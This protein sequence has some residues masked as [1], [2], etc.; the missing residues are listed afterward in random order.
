MMAKIFKF[1]I[2]PLFIFIG[3]TT[4]YFSQ[5]QKIPISYWD[6]YEW[7]GRSYFFELFVKN[8]TKN[9]LWKGLYSYD[10][11][12]LTHYLQGAILYP[13]Y[14]YQKKTK[15][16]TYGYVKFLVDNNFYE[17]EGLNYENYKSKVLGY[18]AW[19]PQDTGTAEELTLKFGDNFQ[20][21]IGLIFAARKANIFLLSGSVLLV[22]LITLISAGFSIALIITPFYG[23]NNLII[24][25]GLV[26]HSEALFLALFNL[27]LLVLILIFA[28]ETK[29]R[30]FLLVIFPTIAGLCASTKLNG[31]MLLIFFDSF[32]LF[33]LIPF[34]QKYFVS[35]VNLLSILAV[36]IFTLF[37]F[38]FLNP[39]LYENPLENTQF[40]FEWRR[41][42]VLLQMGGW[43]ETALPT[44]FD[45]IKQIYSN[46]F[47]EETFNE[48]N[49]IPYPR[50][51]YIFISYVL[52]F[53][54]IL[55]IFST[56][57]II[58]NRTAQGRAYSVI[59]LLFI[60]TQLIMGFYLALNWQRYYVQLVFFIVFFQSI[61]VI[62]FGTILK[63]FLNLAL[64]N[65]N[66]I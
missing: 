54:F 16:E 56:L 12:M 15:G 11:P 18:I 48:Y 51:N 35:K 65:P 40:M 27:G 8:D 32:A 42:M 58:Y 17:A 30:N 23:L 22:Y 29:Y 63:Y 64:S 24:N 13:L 19:T 52:L 26:A 37:I 28:K 33:S 38:V 6:E 20:K 57:L 4:Y 59:L 44:F 50:P 66:K 55:G 21:T 49:T 1:L 41:K 31:F 45:R 9:P 62:S 60:L 25:N 2:I 3:F 34:F 39:F 5:Y 61:G 46:F 14:K 10:Q 36:N 47:A 53:F 43:P 7:V